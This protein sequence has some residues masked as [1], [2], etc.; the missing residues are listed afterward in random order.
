MN[1][2][3]A[4]LVYNAYLESYKLSI[5]GIGWLN[6]IKKM[7]F[8][9]HNKDI[10][11]NQGTVNIKKTVNSLK[12]QLEELYTNAW[13][14]YLFR[15]NTLRTGNKLRVY[16]LF[17]STYERENYL[18]FIK[19]PKSRSNFAKF[20]L[21]AHSLK[22]ESGRYRGAHWVPPYER[23][24]EDCQLGEPQN[25][26]HVLITCPKFSAERQVFLDKVYEIF[27]GVEYMSDW[28]KFIYL[29]SY[30]NDRDLCT[31]VSQFITSILVNN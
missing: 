11:D 7:L 6:S 8:L 17:K 1:G 25:E 15:G 13:H 27:P 19:C 2:D 3:T 9:T 10:W 16:R 18:S 20:R 12:S 23:A 26:F 22:I 21:R 24:C 5:D 14:N 29:M 31:L 28:D 4:S 30:D